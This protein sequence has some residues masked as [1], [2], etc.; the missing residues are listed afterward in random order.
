MIHLTAKS[1]HVT[2]KPIAPPSG[3][4]FLAAGTGQAL[5][6]PCV[7]DWLRRWIS[8]EVRS[9][10]AKTT[11][12]AYNNIIERHAIPALGRFRLS[13]LSAVLL[14]EYYH[15][16]AAERGLSANTVRKH[17]ILLHT[18][19]QSACRLGILDS[20][21]ADLALPPRF[22]LTSAHYY[23]PEQLNQLLS[24]V[25]GHC[26]ELP[27]RLACNLGLRRGE[28]LGLRWKD[29]DFRQGLITICQTRT[30]A[31]SQVVE[32]PPKTVVSCRTLSISA[33]DDL[34]ELLLRL[35]RQ[36]KEH[37]IPCNPEDFLVLDS[38]YR[39][40]HPNVLTSTFTDFVARSG[41]PP[42]TL[43]GLRHTFASVAS[44]AKVPMYQISR[45]MG[46][47][48]P[49]TTQRVYTHLFDPTHGEVL[50]AVAAAI[51]EKESV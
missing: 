29:V 22:E 35:R 8:R 44:S 20:N 15:W 13:Q 51:T 46:H 33:L 43:H 7:A 41:L 27:V 1:R 19:L 4:P 37:R 38:K 40:W 17:H 32:K 45:A 47:S 42:I 14:E 31:G 25:K 24:A 2:L 16:L 34:Q 28:I 48:S 10:H 9:S 36:R 18:S 49:A 23:T 11:Y 3:M 39:P 26:L 50:A 5:E 6:D 21:P 12:Y 30:T